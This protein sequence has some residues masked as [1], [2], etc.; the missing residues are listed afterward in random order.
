MMTSGYTE[1]KKVIGMNKYTS[2]NTGIVTVR[3]YSSPSTHFA[4]PLPVP[5]K[6]G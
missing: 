3:E 5:R 2:M 6:N 1:I 4:T